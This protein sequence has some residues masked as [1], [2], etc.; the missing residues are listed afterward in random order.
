MNNIRFITATA[1]IIIALLSPATS[2]AQTSS[3]DLQ[4][5]ID[6]A[7]PGAL[8][9]VPYAIYNG[10]ITISKPL[11]LKGLPGENGQLPVIDGEGA[12]TVV[13]ITA[14]ETVVEGFEIRASGNVIDR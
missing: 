12:G 3:A 1:I 4:V 8:L 5:L 2:A 7:E 14:P 10:S 11:H 6:T 9:E 13:T